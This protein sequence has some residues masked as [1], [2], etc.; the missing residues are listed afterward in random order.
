MTKVHIKPGDD[1]AGQLA[2]GGVLVLA[3][4]VHVGPLWIERSVT[5][6]G[7][8]GAV[9][10]AQFHGSV[11]RVEADDLEVRLEGL[12][13]RGGVAEVGGGVLLN[14]YSSLILDDCT[15]E[16]NAAPKNGG[17]GIYAARGTLTVSGC[18]FQHN[19][20]RCGGDVLLTGVVEAVF[21]GSQL[22]GDL[23]VREG[24]KLV[25]RDCDVGGVLDLRGTSTRAPAVELDGAQVLGGVRNEGPRHAAVTQ[26]G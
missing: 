26:L 21:E 19:S 6:R 11:V 9:L 18:R 22:D 5:L 4:G 23:A 16:G 14:G 20:G 7:E 8:P 13:L 24:A 1:L 12:T 2:A 10:D 3:A 25:L 17:G 15:I